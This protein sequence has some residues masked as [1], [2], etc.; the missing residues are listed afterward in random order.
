[1]VCNRATPAKI[2][3]NC[4]LRRLGASLALSGETDLDYRRARLRETFHC[5]RGGNTDCVFGTGKGDSRVRGGFDLINHF[6]IAPW[7]AKEA[8]SRRVKYWEI[9]ADKLI[10]L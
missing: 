5:A 9:I 10:K 7:R 8:E 1:M 2:T 3:Q 4:A 6:V